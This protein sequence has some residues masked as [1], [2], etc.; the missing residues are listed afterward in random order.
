M[1]RL[2]L[3]TLQSHFVNSRFL[4]D[5]IF[6]G[7]SYR[8]SIMMPTHLVYRGVCY[9]EGND[10]TWQQNWPFR[11]SNINDHCILRHFHRDV[12]RPEETACRDES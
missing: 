9:A 11:S 6:N 5:A 10:N 4:S 3:M 8:P 2:Q 12:A 7:S 1:G